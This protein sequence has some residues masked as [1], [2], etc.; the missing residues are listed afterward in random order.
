MFFVSVS[1]TLE[2]HFDQF[3]CFAP[4]FYPEQVR[5]SHGDIRLLSSTHPVNV[6]CF[7]YMSGARTVIALLP[8]STSRSQEL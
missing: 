5:H 2:E 6:R 4:P 7:R 1:L 8:G 3:S